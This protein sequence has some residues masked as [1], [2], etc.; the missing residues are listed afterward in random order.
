MLKPMLKH[1]QP[2]H[3]LHKQPKRQNGIALFIALIALVAMTL[4]AIGLM[5]SVDTANLIAGNIAFKQ[6]ATI[7]GD[8]GTEAAI[9]WLS[10]NASALTSNNTTNAGFG[11]FATKNDPTDNNWPAYFDTLKT[12]GTVATLGIDDA[13]GNT[14]SYVIHR[15]CA[16][17]GD[18]ALAANGC[19]STTTTAPDCSCHGTTCEP[20]SCSGLQVY[21]RITARIDGPRNTTSYI[22]SL[23]LF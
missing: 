18:P 10:N 1:S 6:S 13:T 5:R 15:M 14:V 19:V 8:A 20:I 4:A 17:A 22:Q 11:Y 12:A 2:R 3:R 23:V 7:G 16:A 9:T 21:Y